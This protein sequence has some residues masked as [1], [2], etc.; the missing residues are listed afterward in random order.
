MSA[1]DTTKAPARQEPFGLAEIQRK[2]RLD[3]NLGNVPGSGLGD[4]SSADAGS[5][6]AHPAIAGCGGSLNR[7]QIDVPAA[8]AYVVRVT[9]AVTE[10]RTLAAYLTNLCHNNSRDRESPVCKP[11]L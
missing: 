8:T 10:L 6:D 3:G 2:L 1:S 5:A 7:L 11:L 4:F 9:D